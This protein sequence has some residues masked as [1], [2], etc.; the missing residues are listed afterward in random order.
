MGCG[1]DIQPGAQAALEGRSEAW[2]PINA[3]C[4]L[5]ARAPEGGGTTL[6][7]GVTRGRAGGATP[8]GDWAAS[9]RWRCAPVG[10]ASA[11]APRSPVQPHLPAER[12][13][14]R[15]STLLRQ[16]PA[17]RPPLLGSL[18]VPLLP[19]SLSH[20]AHITHHPPQDEINLEENERIK[21]ELNPVK[22]SEPKT[23]YLSPLDSDD[24]LDLGEG[25]GK[26]GWWV[27]DI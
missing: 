4:Q 5:A 18:P 17:A 14:T 12:G 26:G 1:G 9:R 25:Q 13:S 19:P 27:F 21:A 24:E 2:L 11:P 10:A 6:A 23:P 15:R 7:A 8:A 22:I 16:P 20:T 3:P